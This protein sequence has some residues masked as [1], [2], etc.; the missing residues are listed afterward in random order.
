[1]SEVMNN[2]LLVTAYSIY[3][4]IYSLI[5]VK[6]LLIRINIL[7]MILLSYYNCIYYYVSPIGLA[8][9]YFSTYAYIFYLIPFLT[10]MSLEFNLCCIP[11]FGDIALELYNIEK[12]SVHSICIG[13]IIVNMVLINIIM[14]FQLLLLA[15]SSLKNIEQFICCFIS[16]ELYIIVNLLILQYI[17]IY[18]NTKHYYCFVIFMIMVLLG[19]P[20][21]GFLIILFMIASWIIQIASRSIQFGKIF[22]LSFLIFINFHLTPGEIYRNIQYYLHYSQFL[23]YIKYFSPAEFLHSGLN[24]RILIYTKENSPAYYSFPAIIYFVTVYSILIVFLYYMNYKRFYK[25][26]ISL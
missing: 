6:Y 2:K 16:I 8:N 12:C 14:I 3:I 23:E 26:I 25:K 7:F 18:I 15:F 13:N 4:K 19:I 9:T 22:L 1:M 17:S 5:E 24:E 11:S 21:M 10:A 20:Y